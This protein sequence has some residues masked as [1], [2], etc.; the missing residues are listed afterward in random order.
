MTAL[1]GFERRDLIVM[2]S[3]FE[4]REYVAMMR[5]YC[6]TFRRDWLTIPATGR[7]LY[8]RHGEVHQPRGGKIVQPNCLW[9]VLDIIRQAGF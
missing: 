1:P 7:P 3:S 9:D 6:G 2:G 5:H 4:R 8:V